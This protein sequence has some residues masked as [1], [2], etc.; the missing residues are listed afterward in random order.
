MKKSYAYPYLI[1]AVLTTTL[2]FALAE[3]IQHG[4]LPFPAIALL[5]VIIPLV[6]SYW[7]SGVLD[8]LLA[9]R[10]IFAAVSFVIN[11]LLF[12]PLLL[13]QK[14]KN[15]LAFIASQLGVI[16]VYLLISLPFF[17]IFSRWMS[18]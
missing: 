3:Y 6:V 11:L 7:S 5:P 10:F 4:P 18:V 8:S 2:S 17:K 14:F 15:R 13:S 12:F 9:W 16:A 1:A